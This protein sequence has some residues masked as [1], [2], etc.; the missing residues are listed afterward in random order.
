MKVVFLDIDGVLNSKKTLNP[1]NFPYVVDPKLLR[2]LELLLERT[3]AKVVLSSTWRY[4][5]IGR[6]AAN[7]WGI[8]F[9]D[10]TPDMPKQPR[11][12]EI[13]AWL[14]DHADVT[15]YVILD[16]EDDELDDLPL[17]QPSATTGLTDKLIEGAANYLLGASDRDMRCSAVKRFFQNIHS[18]LKGHEG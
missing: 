2:R 1:R 14:R 8:P 16:D 13:V 10:T 18:V 5:P 4:D 11:R 15:R 7:H 6:L 3:G 9:I 12:D 17:F